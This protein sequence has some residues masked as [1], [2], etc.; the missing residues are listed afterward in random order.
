MMK[1]TLRINI[2]KN[3]KI[4]NLNVKIKNVK[5]RYKQNK[6]YAKYVKLSQNLSMIAK[7]VSSSF[8]IS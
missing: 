3:L 1:D 8:R 5:E 7:G 4:I 2:W 6:K